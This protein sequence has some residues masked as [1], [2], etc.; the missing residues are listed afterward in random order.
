V[1]DMFYER[2]RA[3]AFGLWIVRVPEHVTTRKTQRRKR[4]HAGDSQSGRRSSYGLYLASSYNAGRAETLAG[5]GWM[6]G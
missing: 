2:R 3:E 6:D 5:L 1:E 4:I